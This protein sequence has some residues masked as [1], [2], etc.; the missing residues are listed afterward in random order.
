MRCAVKLYVAGKVF[1][2]EMEA[3]NYQDA[4][5]IA[6]ARNPTAKV[7]SVNAVFDSP[8]SSSGIF[9]SG[10]SSSSSTVSTSSG[11]GDMSIQ[12][13][14]SLLVI[15]GGIWFVVTFF[16]WIVSV[17]GGS[18]GY[19]IGEAGGQIGKLDKTNRR[20][21]AL[22]LS[23]ALGIGGFALGTSWQNDWSNDYETTTTEEVKYDYE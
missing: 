17:I 13:F 14:F 1:T 18:I 6:L 9:S 8:S 11:G 2:E 10:S 5:Q 21:V 7:I 20:G 22:L 15:G 12:T 3:V 19:G 23:A 16:P 4:K